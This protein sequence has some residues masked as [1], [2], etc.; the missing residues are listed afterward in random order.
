[1]AASTSRPPGPRRRRRPAVAEYLARLAAGEHAPG[2]EAGSSLKLARSFQA[3][4]HDYYRARVLGGSRFRN[5]PLAELLRRLATGEADPR[6]GER[7]GWRRSLAQ[8]ASFLPPL[9]PTRPALD[10]AARAG[11]RREAAPALARE[12]ERAIFERS[13]RLGQRAVARALGDAAAALERGQPLAA[14]PALS[15]LANAVFAL[16]PYA[17]AFRFQHQDEALHRAVADRFP[18]AAHLK[19]KSAR[20]G[21]ATDTLDDVNGVATTIRPPRRSPASADWR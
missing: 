2:G 17:A 11:A 16:S 8:W 5:D 19:E 13:C 9:G 6:E 15:T 18:A 1:M 12:E 3:L 10:L 7:S 21:W 4:A 14:L 20:V